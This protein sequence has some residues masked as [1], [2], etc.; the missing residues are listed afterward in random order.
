MEKPSRQPSRPH[1]VVALLLYQAGW[2]ACI[3]GA[4]N[5][6]PAAYDTPDAFRPGRPGPL[7]TSFGAGVH[8]C[9]GAPLARLEMRLALQTLFDRCPGLRLTAPPV[10]D[11]TYH[12]HGYS[13]L[14]V[15][16]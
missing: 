13:S 12:F 9:L 4:A 10:L 2:F 6:D 14:L 7:L 11:D 5:R 1:I 16:V 15:S 8:F 3:L